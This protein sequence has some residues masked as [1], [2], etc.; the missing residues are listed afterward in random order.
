MASTAQRLGIATLMAAHCAGMTDLVALPIW[1]GTLISHYQ[2]DAQ[3][4]GGLVTLFLGAGVGASLLLSSRVQRIDG[5]L[6]A[7][8]GFSVAALALLCLASLRDPQGMALLH[9]LAGFATGAALTFTHGAMGRS[10]EP[11]RIF[12]LAGAAFGLYGLLF[13]AT[14]SRLVQLYGGS[15][16]F[17]LLAGIML[18]AALLSALAFPR[19]AAPAGPAAGASA[20]SMPPIIWFGI[21]GM[22]CI[23]LVQAMVFS[24]LERI[25]VARG[26]EAGQIVALLTCVGLCNLL[27]AGASALLERRLSARRVIVAG[28]LLQA[29]IALGITCAGALSLFIG[30]ALVFV[31]VIVFTHTFLFGLLARLDRSGRAVAATPAMM[32]AGSA[33]GPLLGG[34]LVHLGGFAPL[35]LAAICIDGL[36]LFCMARLA[37][38]QRFAPTTA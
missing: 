34:T 29:F 38:A 13:L 4:A 10:A 31:S 3:Q 2:L 28:P 25:A 32:M 19:L 15:A 26:L 8:L 20:V 37:L 12:G 36:A 7:L 6:G 33:L 27:V 24:F 35:G 30:A 16:L 21:L 17:L 14:A 23:A 18:L 5:R 1:V 11:H 22:S 9:A